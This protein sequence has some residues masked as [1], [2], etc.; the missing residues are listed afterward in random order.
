VQ[1]TDHADIRQQQT[2]RAVDWADRTRSP[3]AQPA[4]APSSAATES[5]IRRCRALAPS[6]TAFD[7]AQ[8]DRTFSLLLTDVGMIRFLP[9]LIAHVA[10]VAP[11]VNIRAIHWTRVSSSS[12]WR[13]VSRFWRLVH[14]RTPRVTCR[15]QPIVFRRLRHGR[16]QRPSRF[17]ALRSRAGFLAERHI[18]VTASETGHA[19][20]RTAHRVLTSQIS[21]ANVMLQ[22]PSFIA[23]AIVA[24]ETDGLRRCRP[25]W[26][27]V[28]PVRLG[29]HIRNADQLAAHRNFAV[30]A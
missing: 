8:S 19:A 1:E 27:N 6:D 7:P 2:E 11:Q 30:L 12:S 22:V 5:A 15:R 21:P 16:A 17:A 23:G 13:P 9:P 24:A 25:I 10:A 20:H 18:V 3:G 14:F 26:Q 4:A 29:D 28:S